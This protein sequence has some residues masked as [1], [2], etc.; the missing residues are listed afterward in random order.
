MTT[1]HH[2]WDVTTTPGIYAC[3]ECPDTAVDCTE[4][5][6][7]I[8]ESHLVACDRCIERA[9]TWVQ[10]VINALATVP[11]HHAEI[12]GLRAV[13]YDLDVVT[14]G[15]D[16]DRLPFG[17]DAIVEDVEDPRIS[18]ARHPET[19]V[20][21]LRG[22][23]RAWADARGDDRPSDELGYLVRLTQWAVQNPD[24][25]GWGVYRDEARQV[26]ATVRR[27]LGLEPVREP[28]PCVH[29]AGDVIREWTPDGLDD[30]RRCTRCAMTWPDEDRL[31]FTNHLRILAAPVTDPD[32][33]VTLEQARI[34][35][36]DLKRNTI[37]QVIKRD[38][39]RTDPEHPDHDPAYEPRL[40]ARGVDT[41]GRILYRLGDFAHLGKALAA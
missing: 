32:T 41:R 4:G 14:G 16:R 27:L 39:D 7:R 34:A 3:T 13:R 37:N 31:R 6:G 1:H 9:R 25:S 35:L 5:C 30:V 38:R 28:A 8:L 20:D 33:L 36:P 29:C 19:A 23:A 17:L 10:D 11:F 26:R 12:M 24:A 2:T 21:V 15:G 22:W 40:P 18:A